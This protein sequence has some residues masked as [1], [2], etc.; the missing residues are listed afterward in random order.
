MG[1]PIPQ[2]LSAWPLSLAAWPDFLTAWHQGSRRERIQHLKGQVQ[3]WH[4]FH[5]IPL[6]KAVCK[7]S[8]KAE[9]RGVNPLLMGEGP[10]HAW[11]EKLLVAL[12][13]NH[14]LQMQS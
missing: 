7:A 5:H 14:F 8:P 12:F 6:I 13:G 10:V 4:Y 1:H 11:M 2:D 3:N 9:G